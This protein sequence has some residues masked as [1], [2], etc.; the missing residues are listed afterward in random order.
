MSAPEAPITVLVT[1][2]DHHGA[3]SRH[4]AVFEPEGSVSTADHLAEAWGEADFVEAHFGTEHAPAQPCLWLAGVLRDGKPVW[5]ADGFSIDGETLAVR[6]W[7]FTVP[8]GVDD[9]S[10]YRAFMAMNLSP[11]ASE[12][13][14]TRPSLVDA[15]GH[16]VEAV[17]AFLVDLLAAAAEA[18]IAPVGT[19]EIINAF[20][21]EAALPSRDDVLDLVSRGVHWQEALGLISLGLD[22]SSAAA[23][24][25]SLMSDPDF[26]R[27][28]WYGGVT[29]TVEYIQ[30]LGVP[31]ARI[32]G[33]LQSRG[34]IGPPTGLT[35]EPMARLRGLVAGGPG[36]REDWLAETSAN[37]PWSRNIAAHYAGG[38]PVRAM[39]GL[40]DYAGLAE[41]YMGMFLELAAGRLNA[42]EDPHT[43]PHNWMYPSVEEIFERFSGI[44]EQGVNP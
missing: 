9:A 34:T 44:Q 3:T 8:D 39:Q 15:R 18:G 11:E 17:H 28:N 32:P 35:E 23:I 40:S 19:S 43:W 7:E 13:E 6:D 20:H 12:Q 29:Q 37:L 4:R 31:L 24:H 14:F 1:C 33:L 41:V 21:L 30:R 22:V 38:D 36:D 5:T 16:D 42:G 27:D 10:I 26:V 25:E 2:S